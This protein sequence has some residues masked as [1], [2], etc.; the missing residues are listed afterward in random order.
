[1]GKIYS[2]GV[3][4]SYHFEEIGEV[5]TGLNTDTQSVWFEIRSGLIDVTM[6]FRNE[7]KELNKSIDLAVTTLDEIK[8][9]LEKMRIK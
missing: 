4:S 2:T 1:M 6:F 9:Q 3:S 8:A 7:D 5:K